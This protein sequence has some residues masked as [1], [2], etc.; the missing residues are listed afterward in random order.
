MIQL[1]RV[2]CGHFIVPEVLTADYVRGM[3]EMH[4]Q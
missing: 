1:L 3:P 2:F 4:E